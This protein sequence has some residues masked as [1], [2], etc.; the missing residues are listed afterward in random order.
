M[1]ESLVAGYALR[2]ERKDIRVFFI[3]EDLHPMNIVLCKNL[4]AQEI[5]D[6]VCRL[7]GTATAV[8]GAFDPPTH[9]GYVPVIDRSTRK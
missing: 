4:Q 3:D 2:R 8:Q 1:P 5:I 7:P 6:A 9:P